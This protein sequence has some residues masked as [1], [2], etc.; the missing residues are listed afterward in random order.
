MLQ[1]K[2]T[3][4]QREYEILLLEELVPE[5]HLLSSGGGFQLHPRIVQGL[6]FTQHRPSCGIAGA[7]IPDVVSGVSLRIKSEVKLADRE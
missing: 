3:A 4:S 6:V 2:T 5:D 1:E 7:S